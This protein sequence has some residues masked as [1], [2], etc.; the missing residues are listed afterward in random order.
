MATGADSLCQTSI[1][2]SYE[3][4]GST[5]YGTSNT[6][7]TDGPETTVAQGNDIVGQVDKYMKAQTN[8]AI[9]EQGRRFFEGKPSCH[10]SRCL[11]ETLTGVSRA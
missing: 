1:E 10:R 9:V 6:C 3:T 4:L 5:S 7:H 11:H 2:G 8:V